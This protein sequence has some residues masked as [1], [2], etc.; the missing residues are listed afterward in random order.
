MSDFADAFDELE[1][2]Q[3]SRMRELGVPEE[4]ITR[5]KKHKQWKDDVALYSLIIKQRAWEFDPSCSL[6][7]AYLRLCSA[8]EGLTR[9]A[10]AIAR[11]EQGLERCPLSS[12]LILALAKLLFKDDQK[13][14]SLAM[15]EKVFEMYAEKD[16]CEMID[17]EGD[18]QP[19]PVSAEDAE[20]AYYL[21]GWVK[22]HDDNHTEAYRIWQDG[23][24][25]VPSSELLAIQHRKRFCWD[26]EFTTVDP[27]VSQ[28]RMMLHS[29][30]Y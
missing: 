25:A 13:E 30:L 28:S 22:I 5:A 23:H 1:E 17:L 29:F 7:E 18:Q 10:E 8:L 21:G 9:R 6:V 2:Q 20:D 27:R 16:N 24:V 19:R 12:E 15:C 14:K 4:D 26:D 3:W 11:L